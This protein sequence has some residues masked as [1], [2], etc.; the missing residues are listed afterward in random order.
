[1]TPNLSHRYSGEEAVGGLREQHER[2]LSARAR[3]WPKRPPPIVVRSRPYAPSAHRLRAFLEPD[4]IPPFL[5]LR[6][7]Q[8]MV[9]FIAAR[10]ASRATLKM[11]NSRVLAL[12]EEVARKHHLSVADLRSSSRL[13]HITDARQEAYFRMRNEIE[14]KGKPMSFPSIGKAM[15]GRDHT[16][17]LH[18]YHK[19]AARMETRA[20]ELDL[21]SPTLLGDDP[22]LANAAYEACGLPALLEKLRELP[23]DDPRPN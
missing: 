15:G 13:R 1:M 19:H 5:P 14:V 7:G 2:Y 17:A 3:L 9:D 10:K 23:E 20:T 12:I 4:Y 8:V 22:G 21:G 16:S 6:R 11:P 18:G